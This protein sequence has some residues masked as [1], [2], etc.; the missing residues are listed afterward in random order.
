MKRIT[1][2]PFITIRRTVENID[3]LYDISIPSE[4]VQR[5]ITIT[6]S[7]WFVF[8]IGFK[9]K[10]TGNPQLFKEEEGDTIQDVY[11]AMCEDEKLKHT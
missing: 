2:T 4:Y 6:V 3:E 7:D 10:F 1:R 11:R 8:I 5:T 9:T